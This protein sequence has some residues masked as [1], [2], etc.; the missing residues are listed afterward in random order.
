MLTAI[1]TPGYAPFEQYQ[2]AGNQGAWT[3][4]YALGG[5]MYR[6]ITGKK[7]PEATARLL[8]TDPYKELAVTYRGRYD[9]RFLKAIDRALKTKESERP[10]T[11]AQWRAMLPS[12]VAEKPPVK[13]WPLRYGPLPTVLL[14][15]ALC[16]TVTI[17]FWPSHPA[18]PVPLPT[19]IPTPNPF[20]S[21]TPLPAP[22]AKSVAS[23]Q[24]V[25]PDSF[26][27]IQKAIDAAKPGDT[28]HVKP[29]DY[30]EPLTLKEGITLEGENSGSTVVRYSA[31]PTATGGQ[32]YYSAP[33]DITN[34]KSGK[35]RNLTFTQDESDSRSYQNNSNIYK[36]DA[37]II[38]NSAVTIENCRVTSL[39]G[40]GI[41]V[42]GASAAPSLNHN[43]CTS[44]NESGITVR[45]GA[46]CTLIGNS[47]DGNQEIGI[48]VGDANTNAD[49]ISN[50][51][52]W[53]KFSGIVF[54]VGGK[55]KA[56]GNACNEN[57]ENGIYVYGPGTTAYVGNNECRTNQFSGIC[58]QN[59]AQGTASQNLC[60]SNKKFGVI[61]IDPATRSEL[62]GNQ[63]ISNGFSGIIFSNTT[64][65]KASR[66]LCRS[67]GGHGI[68]LELSSAFL[69]GNELKYN[70]LAGLGYDRKSTPTYGA[71][72]IFD[73]N[74][75]GNIDRQA[76][77]E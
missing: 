74:S 28:V 33:L 56:T 14:A 52:R 8:G 13:P 16:V 5:V 40:S 49:I 30:S 75:A 39:A 3:D 51:C 22:T 31:A 45:S 54:S 64:D 4:I 60:D 67:N 26:P 62:A 2:E 69:D 23:N 34:C 32:N 15:V 59:G 24:L 6:A 55:G 38:V 44:N 29:G 77:F 50:N 17:V 68:A 36:I 9:P 27:T 43:Q 42:Y 12:D 58:F 46:K 41:G 20:A 61:V 73:G 53:N 66:N 10:Q 63:C 72:Q 1:V 76:K 19:P 65:S 57:G 70:K 71:P 47:C 35:V 25:V 48:Y 21:S 11:I 37:I 7:P 18:P